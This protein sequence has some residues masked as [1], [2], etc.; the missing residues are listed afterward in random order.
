MRRAGCATL[1]S[2]KLNAVARAREF[3][4]ARIECP[5]SGL[6]S[7]AARVTLAGK[8]IDESAFGRGAVEPPEA[9]GSIS[10]EFDNEVIVGALVI[11]ARE[12]FVDRRAVEF[13]PHELRPQSRGAE[14]LAGS[15]PVGEIDREC[16]VVNETDRFK[17][18]ELG[19]GDGRVNLASPKQVGNLGPRL[20]TARDRVKRDILGPPRVTGVRI[21]CGL[22]S[23]RTRRCFG[24]SQQKLGRLRSG[25]NGLLLGSVRL[26]F[27]RL[28]FRSLA[29]SCLASYRLASSCLEHPGQVGDGREASS[30]AGGLAAS[31]PGSA[32]VGHQAPAAARSTGCSTS[33][34]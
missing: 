29:S 1:D 10:S 20:A 13:A 3:V 32:R 6:T 14:L 31:L 17:A 22:A 4:T 28:G 11:G 21:V 25:V 24:V 5:A 34:A 16:S 26:G 15:E 8:V 23:T 12:C 33:S 9:T 19:L 30:S 18:I 27:R 2:A 7:G